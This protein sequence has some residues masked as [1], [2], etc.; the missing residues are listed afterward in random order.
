MVK[1]GRL[2]TV[3]PT[4]M[5]LFHIAYPVEKRLPTFVDGP[6]AEY[7]RLLTVGTLAQTGN[8][9]AEAVLLVSLEL[10]HDISAR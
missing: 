5:I 7:P 1:V 9:V 8:V 4:S 2:R 3:E 6:V 10:N